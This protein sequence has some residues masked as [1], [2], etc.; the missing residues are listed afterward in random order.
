MTVYLLRHGETVYNAQK[1]YLGKTDLPLS[2]KGRQELV[3]ADFSPASVYISPLQRTA[4]T[5]DILF[6]GVRQIVV[7]GFQEMDFGVF[8]G[9][10]AAEMVHDADYRQWVDGNCL[11]LI[12]KGESRAI[13]SRRVCEAFDALV[14][15]GL[16]DGAER[17]VIVAHGGTQM[18][19]M[20]RYA[21]PYR[22]YYT[23]LGPNGGGYVLDVSAW[24]Q[25][26]PLT[27]LK[28]IQYTKGKQV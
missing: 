5:A 28:T 15:Q 19:V 13:F 2:P 10:S 25:D 14:L 1:R 3:R 9:R 4:Q 21:Q 16:A 27:L 22:D 20:T 12:P 17:L 8:E 26:R 23:W 11:G 18:A 24:N 6:P 7:P